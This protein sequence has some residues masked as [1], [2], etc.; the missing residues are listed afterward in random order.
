M[1]LALK[2]ENFSDISDIQRDVTELLKEVSLQ[3]SQRAVE[4]LYKRPQ[5]CVELGGDYIE[6]W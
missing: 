5:N 4:N 3:D 6:S 1:K 2:E